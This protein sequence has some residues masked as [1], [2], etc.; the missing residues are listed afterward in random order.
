MP[1]LTISWTTAREQ[2]LSACGEAGIFEEYALIGVT[3]SEDKARASGY[4]SC[5]ARERDDDTNPSACVNGSTGKYKDAKNGREIDIWQLAAN[6]GLHGGDWEAARR[7]YLDK[8]NVDYPKKG[9]GKGKRAANLKAKTSSTVTGSAPSAQKSPSPRKPLKDWRTEVHPERRTEDKKTEH[10]DRFIGHFKI[11]K[12]GFSRESFTSAGGFYSRWPHGRT[13]EDGTAMESFYGVVGVPVYG[14]SVVELLTAPATV[15]DSHAVGAIIW[16]TNALPFE[17]KRIGKDGKEEISESKMKTIGSADGF[18]GH[19]GL[20][21]IADDRARVARGEPSTITHIWKV[22]G[23][24]DLFALSSLIPASLRSAN[25]ILSLAGGSTSVPPWTAEVIRGYEV[26]VCHD[27]DAAGD[28]GAVKTCEL[29]GPAARTIYTIGL[30]EVGETSIVD[31]ATGETVD[32]TT[33]DLRKRILANSLTFEDLTDALLLAMPYEVTEADKEAAAR[34]EAEGYGA[35]NGPM[36]ENSAN[37]D[38]DL[39]LEPL[40]ADDDPHRLARVYLEQNAWSIEFN[41]STLRFWRQEWHVW[42]GRAYVRLDPTDLTGLVNKAIKEEFDRLN[43]VAQERFARRPASDDPDAPDEKPPV[44]RKVSRGLVLDVI[45]AI[46]GQCSLPSDQEAPFWISGKGPWPASEGF[47][48]GSGIIHLASLVDGKPDN[49]Y[50]TTPDFFSPNAVH[51]GFPNNDPKQSPHPTRWHAFLESLWAD[52]YQQIQLLQEWMGYCLLP[53]TSQ[54]KLLLFIGP[55]RSGKGTIA[56]TLT[57]LVGENNVVNPRLSQFDKEYGMWPLVGKTVA[58]IGDARLSGRTDTAEIVETL[59]SI[60]GEDKQTVNRKH[61]SYVHT[62]LRTRFTILSNA[63]P[64]LQDTSGAFH[65]RCLLLE[66]KHSFEGREDK[67][68]E[69]ELNAELPGILVW[70]IQGWARLRERGYFEQPDSSK[71]ALKQF[72]YLTSPM[73]KF[74]DEFCVVGTDEWVNVDVAYDTYCDFSK[75]NRLI[76]K[77]KPVFARDLKSVINHMH[78]TQKRDKTGERFRVFEGFRLKTETELYLDDDE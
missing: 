50:P 42:N 6:V 60:S 34:R 68:L 29:W 25:P 72:E 44:T 10:V 55:K 14:R 1:A 26:V 30:R 71:N 59:L 49:L 32:L 40:E 53:D 70:A 9:K 22:E 56:R 73:K 45:A 76:I 28:N 57:Q 78:T 46:Q 12:G 66:T 35:D 63:M 54:Q 17:D 31:P 38:A 39:D 7:H 33:A 21:L 41:S 77:P 64:D 47:A 62:R 61:M 58:I 67:N 18:I 24:T 74:L 36:G 51:Y 4:R 69:H 23:P 5:Y 19:Y 48:T 52:D 37:P 20:Q 27:P 11:K 8:Y 13:R 2:F 3:F 65:S 43:V 15:D 75:S 16:R